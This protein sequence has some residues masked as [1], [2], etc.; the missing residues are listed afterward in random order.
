MDWING[1]KLSKKNSRPCVVLKSFEGD[2]TPL[3]EAAKIPGDV[4]NRSG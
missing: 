2:Q 3:K 4:Q 1:A